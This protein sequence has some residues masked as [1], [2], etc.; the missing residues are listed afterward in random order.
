VE[1]ADQSSHKIKISNPSSRVDYERG[2]KHSIRSASVH[3]N[4]N[5]KPFP[6][7]VPTQNAGTSALQECPLECNSEI[8]PDLDQTVNLENSP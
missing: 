4:A 6:A 7:H 5:L 3:T 1:R 2:T 8:A